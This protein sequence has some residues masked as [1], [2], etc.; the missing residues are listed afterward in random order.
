M[1]EKNPARPNIQ[2]ENINDTKYWDPNYA[3]ARAGVDIEVVV[4][5]ALAKK[6]EGPRDGVATD[7]GEDEIAPGPLFQVTHLARG[8]GRNSVAG[9]IFLN[10]RFYQ[11][12]A[13]KKGWF[14]ALGSIPL[15]FLYYIA[16]TI[17]WISGHAIWLF[18]RILPQK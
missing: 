11:F 14:F 2:C 4:K 5:S 7:I 9:A 12:L 10:R 3:P 17:G 16:A 8:I 1:P 13:R 18:G 6:E 15:H